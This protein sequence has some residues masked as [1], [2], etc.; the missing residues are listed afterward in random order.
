MQR[1]G[2][3]SG[4]TLFATALSILGLVALWPAFGVA[5]H[6]SQTHVS[7][8][9]INGN[10]N[11]DSI[12]GGVS[13]DGAHDFF[14]TQEQLVTTDT[15]SSWDIYERF[16]NTTTHVSA[17]TINGNGA[18]DA[19]FGANSPDGLRVWFETKEK[20]VTADTDSMTDVYERSGA[21]TTLVSQGSGNFNTTI[22]S[23]F[24][25]ASSDG[26][27]VF[28]SSYDRLAGT[29]LDSN[30]DIFVRD[31][32]TT[33]QISTGGNGPY[34]ADFTGMT[35]DGSRVYFHTDEQLAGTDGDTTRDV[36][37]ANGGTVTQ[38]S[39]GPGGTG[40]NGGQ[41]PVFRAVTA[42]GA[43]VYF[44][45]TEV[46]A[47]TDSDA[48]LDVYDRTGGTTVQISLAAGAGNG[49]YDASFEAV[50]DDGSKVWFITREPLDP[51][52]LDGSTPPTNA[53]ED[54]TGGLT[55]R[56]LDLYQRS[57]ST[58][59]WIS[60][61]P[62]ENNAGFEA[63]FAAASNDGS[64]VFFHTGE[65]LTLD[66]ADTE[67]SDVYQRAGSVTTLIS[68]GTT[69][70]TGPH[71][72]QLVGISSDGVR[73]FFHTYESLVPEDDDGNWQDVYERYYGDTPYGT[74]ALVSTGPAANN[75]ASIAFYYG[76]TADGSKVFFQT[77]EHLVTTDTD[78]SEDIYS[79]ITVNPG[80]ARPKGATP[81]VLSLVPAFS[82]C[83]SPNRTHGAP[84]SSG[85]C[86][87]PTQDSSVLTVGS[88][89]ANGRAASLVGK[90]KLTA[91][92]ASPENVALDINV[93]DVLCRDPA[94]A[95]PGGALSDFAGSLVVKVTL[96][97]TDR[98]NGSP[99]VEGAT[100]QSY[101]LKIPLTCVATPA[102]S[103]AGGSCA[104]NTTVNT[105]YPGTVANQ[106]R[107]LWQV[108]RVEVLDPGP[109][110][111]IGSC[112]G[113][114]GDGDE[115]VFLRPGVFVP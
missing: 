114:C 66:D 97:I 27:K 80:Y 84:L 60:T 87:P 32:G 71:T 61:S 55:L 113:A 64:K 100:M 21:A 99:S 72:A 7:Q 90:V 42:N 112:P 62:L 86:A 44:Q 77:D 2:P 16:N 94:P 102:Q 74:T 111:T 53:C 59:T 56:C 76:Q 25:G 19:T 5:T 109:N 30:R 89:D 73:V 54:Q 22:D 17:G 4:R 14:R 83:T 10:G 107:A 104:A 68:K 40:G 79:A 98:S 105:L 65:P 67:A 35:P 70:G 101:D 48:N 106:K 95:C 81:L 38:V 12:Y 92:S 63:S 82:D 50:S 93:T 57:G 52:D 3:F 69:G 13:D 91:I 6:S 23:F 47:G 28:V 37:E 58:T 18:F 34:G 45:T 39:R 49:P 24:L 115:T 75:A 20:L 1:R 103:T 9:Q 85:S 88:P 43:H 26:T 78:A 31:G 15:D 33:T 8:G 11:F 110:G 41:I 51:D 96:R 108:D 46:L 29:D 36:Y